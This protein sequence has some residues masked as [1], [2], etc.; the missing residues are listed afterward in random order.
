MAPVVFS[1]QVVSTS[2]TLLPILLVIPCPPYVADAKIN[3]STASIVLRKLNKSP[4]GPAK[5]NYMAISTE[6][7]TGMNQQYFQR[8]FQLEAQAVNV[9]IMFDNP[10]ANAIQS[11]NDN[12]VSFRLRLDGED[13][14]DRDVKCAVGNRSPLYYDRLAMTLLNGNY[15]LK[16]GLEK[17][18]SLGT[19][20]EKNLTLICNPIPL[21]QSDKLL[22]LNIVT[23]QDNGVGNMV[24]FKQVM[25]SIA[26]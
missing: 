1:L 2:D 17:S 18:E 7:F 12:I 22:Q 5:L 10:S 19:V 3:I 23:T 11:N 8:M 21:T 14:T 16:C 15:R 13:L 24:L 9:I 26:M 20:P 6:Q 4:A 25:R